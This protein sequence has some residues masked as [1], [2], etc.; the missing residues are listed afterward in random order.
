MKAARVNSYGQSRQNAN[1]T[2]RS[3]ASVEA[4][5]SLKGIGLSLPSRMAAAKACHSARWPL[6]WRKRERND[7]LAAVANQL[8]EAKILQHGHAAA[9]ENLDALLGIRLVA[10]GEITDRA[11]RPVGELQAR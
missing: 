8:E 1:L 4:T 2:A 11:L 10:V 3:V 5:I 7:L 9:A 6:S